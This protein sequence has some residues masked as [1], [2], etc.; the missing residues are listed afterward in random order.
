MRGSTAVFRRSSG[1]RSP[2]FSSLHSARSRNGAQ[3]SYRELE[4]HRAAEQRSI[5]HWCCPSSS[6]PLRW[7]HLRSS[8]GSHRRPRHRTQL[9]A[10]RRLRFSSEVGGRSRH[11]ILVCLPKPACFLCLTMAALARSL[12]QEGSDVIV[13]SFTENRPFLWLGGN[14]K[15]CTLLFGGLGTGW[16]FPSLKGVVSLGRRFHPTIL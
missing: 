12:S 4:T 14:S 11:R 7:T 1:E 6:V 2:N 3:A 8:A 16:I 13:G 10:S 5:R 15:P 9:I